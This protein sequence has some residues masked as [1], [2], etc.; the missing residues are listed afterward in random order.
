M[1]KFDL[2][3]IP[4]NGKQLTFNLNLR[5]VRQFVTRH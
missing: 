1:E 5:Q 2:D 3:T 4:K